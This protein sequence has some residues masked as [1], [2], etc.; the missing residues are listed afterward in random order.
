MCR[1]WALD[2]RLFRERRQRRGILNVAI[3][4]HLLR[5]TGESYSDYSSNTRIQDDMS[6]CSVGLRRLP[7]RTVRFIKILSDFLIHSLTVLYCTVRTLCP[8]K[9]DLSAHKEHGY[10]SPA[11]FISP[12]DQEQSQVMGPL[13]GVSSGTT[14]TPPEGSHEG[15]HVFAVT[16]SIPPLLNFQSVC[17]VAFYDL[18]V[19]CLKRE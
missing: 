12:L 14:M 2:G 18:M 1:T 6:S 19:G 13:M 9:L 10:I 15:S 4:L 17:T 11:C 3:A 5:L 7:R 8:V 16:R